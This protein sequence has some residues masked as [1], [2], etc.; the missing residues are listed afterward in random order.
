MAVEMSR[1]AEADEEAHA[2]AYLARQALFVDLVKYVRERATRCVHCSDYAY[3]R[4]APGAA[5]GF[6]REL[7]LCDAHKRP[8]SVAIPGAGVVRRAAAV[9]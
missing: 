6:P 4:W 8:G 2:K 9:R 3:W 7:L 1:A 5:S